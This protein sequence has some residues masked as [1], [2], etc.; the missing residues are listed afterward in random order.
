MARNILREIMGKA[1]AR[2]QD[3]LRVLSAIQR[4]AVLMAFELETGDLDSFGRLLWEHWALSKRLDPGS[5]NTCIDHMIAVCT[6]LIDGVMI[7]GAGGGG[8]LS[9]L[10]KDGV[11]R[12]DLRDRLAGVFQESGVRVW[13]AELA[14]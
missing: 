8:F 9:M 13:N 14:R 4:L 7:C 10:L 1:V 11:T 2:D 5:S 6:D 3:T 12:A